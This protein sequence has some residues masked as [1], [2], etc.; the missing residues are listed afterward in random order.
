MSETKIYVVCLAA[1]NNGLSHG[2]WIDANQSPEE[3]YSAIKKMLKKSPIKNAEEWVI[4]GDAG[5][6][7]IISENESIETICEMAEFIEEHGELGSELLVYTG[8]DIDDAKR[9]MND[10]YHGIYSNP[11]DFAENL[12]EETGKVPVNLAFYIDYEKMANDLFINDF[13]FLDVSGKIH[14][15]S[16]D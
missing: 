6:G 14:V 5:F 7:C 8:S 2:K 16:H 1:Y 11:A 4:H 15:F 9:F 12:T 10:C 13:F 3:M